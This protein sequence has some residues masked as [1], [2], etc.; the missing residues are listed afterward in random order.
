M[1]LRSSFKVRT[2]HPAAETRR[3]NLSLECE[4]C[5]SQIL[6]VVSSTSY[7]TE[8]SYGRDSQ[9]LAKTSVIQTSHEVTELVLQALDQTTRLLARPRKSV[10]SPTQ[11]QRGLP[12]T[13]DKC[14]TAFTAAVT[15]MRSPMNVNNMLQF[16]GC[17]MMCVKRV[18]D[19]CRTTMW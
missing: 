5:V 14:K 8:G 15:T 11:L 13:F 18:A 7:P 19:Q 3:L 12:A 2:A 6:N 10:V 4:A 9:L 16:A 17:F 1:I